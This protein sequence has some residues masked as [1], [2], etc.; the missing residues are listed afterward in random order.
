[1]KI[2]G[3]SGG[4]CLGFGNGVGASSPA[5]S[6]ST[7]YLQFKGGNYKWE[8]S[9]DTCQVLA[10]KT[11][12]TI[13]V[14]VFQTKREQAVG[15]NLPNNHFWHIG[16]D[17]G[18]TDFFFIDWG[19]RL[20]LTQSVLDGSSL[21]DIPTSGTQNSEPVKVL[22]NSEN[23]DT[24]YYVSSTF[25]S[26]IWLKIAMVM[27]SDGSTKTVYLYDPQLEELVFEGFSENRDNTPNA[28]GNSLTLGSN[29][30]NGQFHTGGLSFFRIWNKAC[31]KSEVLD[32][33]QN[34]INSLDSDLLINID[35]EEGS[36]RP[37]DIINNVAATSGTNQE[38]ISWETY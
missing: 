28:I 20:N 25:A 36:G 24:D 16:F 22:V 3:M 26:P 6:Q 4:N 30:S 32:H 17:N 5:L 10:D 8:S 11:V 2:F 14:E 19:D 33:F 35:L 37:K 12:L 27:E 18:G 7:K 9:S 38:N 31:T 1:M 23:W 13:E 15:I 29:A 34:G 21:D